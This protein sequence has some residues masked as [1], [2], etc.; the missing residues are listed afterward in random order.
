MLPIVECQS[1]LI[2]GL[3]EGNRIILQAPTGSGK[4]TQ[5]P[6]M[7]LDAGVAEGEIVVLQPRRLAA[8]ML[9]KRVAK[10][11]GGQVGGEVGYQV[12]LDRNVS[13]T[14]QI[15]Y[16]TEGILL[17]E[18][19]KNPLLPH[20]GCIVFDEFHER[21][22]YGD[23]TL[24]H[25]L[26]LQAN[27]RPDLKLI[28]MSAT[29][30][31]E[32]LE[33]F[34]P[35][36][37]VVTSEGRTFPVDVQFLDRPA[38]PMKTKVWDQATRAA[39][40]LVEKTEG[41]VL[42][43]MPG[44]Y[45]IDRT[46]ESLKRSHLRTNLGIYPL[47]GDLSAEAQD[48]AVTPGSE[49]RVIVSTNIAETSLT[50]EGVTGVVD[51]GLARQARFDPHRKTDH[52]EVVPISKASA[53]QR[54]GRAGRTA[55]GTCIRLW[56]ETAH[57]RRPAR[58][59]PEIHRVDL[60]EAVLMFRKLGVTDWSTLALPDPPA[61]NVLEATQTFLSQLGALSSEGT[62]TQLGEDL[63]EFPAHPRIGR[64]L[65]EAVKRGVA[66]RAAQLAGLLQGRSILIRRVSEK[67]RQRLHDD[68]G[69][70]GESDLL[71]ELNALEWAASV[72][73]DRGMCAEA[74]IHA[75]TARQAW[76]IGKQFDRASTRGEKFR[77]SEEPKDPSSE[78]RKCIA[79]AFA[80]QVGLRRPNT[81]RCDLVDGR[82]VEIVKE[83]CCVK[84]EVVV[85][86]EVRDS[87]RL[88]TPLLSGVTRL[89]REWIQELWP[90]AA[91]TVEEVVFD[92][93]EKRVIK[94]RTVQLGELVLEKERIHEV[95]DQE[96]GEKLLAAVDSGE[97]PFPGW[98]QEVENWIVRCNCLAAWQPEW[99]IP[100]LTQEDRR[101][102]MEHMLSGCRTRKDV[103]NLDV[104]SAV[105]DWVTP[106][107]AQLIQDH[108]PQRIKLPNGKNARV[109]YEEGSA[110]IL[111]S[112]LQNFFGM[113]E[114]PV[115]AGGAM[116][117]K[118]EL[119]APNG[120]PAALTDDLTS[121]WKE[122]YL[123]VRKDLRGRYPKHDWPETP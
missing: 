21:H 15:R 10:E 96:A 102:L 65:L 49:R 111:S 54:A 117:C 78:L 35:D 120:R 104:K 114:S 19:L 44:R 7:V 1:E 108:M 40:H 72:R 20:V 58:E 64:L 2:A 8:R 90:D 89:E 87:D 110:P 118:I 5:V 93:Q 48:R 106:M 36:A 92:S 75:Q 33:A 45:E 115:I 85:G 41:D 67:V 53:D 61:G 95:S 17:R 77:T 83:S 57:A 37:K 32:S 3:Q 101:V 42:I 66:D 80:D 69:G 55:P 97:I 107:Q 103:K 79:V 47:H 105:L 119:L 109:R 29:L 123:L 34:L 81:R 59:T 98:D 62:L 18:W 71:M 26:R 88:K 31:T 100:P 12:R 76:Q 84:A 13:S 74:G 122:G 52:L 46:I 14:T 116:S 23:L 56:T 4:S 121:F 39:E 28:L 25:A 43:F 99:G 51:S 11:R 86:V 9:A 22:L 63:L 94:E 112:K 24:A 60:A 6:G 91:R 68:F 82:V 30:Q 27:Q 70:E 50:L 73:F 16:V 113:K 38:D